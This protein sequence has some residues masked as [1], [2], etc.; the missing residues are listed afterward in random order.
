MRIK[1]TVICSVLVL[2]GVLVF[3]IHRLPDLYSRDLPY[4]KPKTSEKI[5]GIGTS[6]TGTT[7]LSLALTKLGYRTWHCPP[8]ND[9]ETM[10]NY[11]NKFDALTDFS[12]VHTL[13]AKRSGSLDYKDLYRIYPKAKFILTLRKDDSRWL[14]SLNYLRKYA[15][16]RNFTVPFSAYKT[17]GQLFD[18]VLRKP[19]KELLEQYHRYNNEVI[20]FFADKPGSLLVVD[21]TQEEDKWDKLCAFL[22]KAHPNS[23]FPHEDPVWFHFKQLFISPF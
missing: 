22:G 21:L 12:C 3:W 18:V 20:C 5:F 13:F 11:I 19:D 8:S 9:L 10:R 16:A 1:L 17:L 4:P 2:V 15:T 7:S 23:K 14:R 6:R